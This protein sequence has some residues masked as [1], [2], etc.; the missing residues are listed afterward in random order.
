MMD[1]IHTNKAYE[2]ELKTLRDRILAM[3]GRVEKMIANS[4]KALVLNDIA[5]AKS[6]IEFDRGIDREEMLIDK[7][8]LEMLARRQ[9]LGQDLRFIVCVLKMVTYF[10][11][12]GDLAVKISQRVASLPPAT[13]DMKLDIIEAMGRSVQLMVRDTVEAFLLRDVHRAKSVLRQDD[14]LD[15]NYHQ[16]M[17][18]YILK[19]N[20]D[21]QDVEVY[22]HLLSIAKWLE[23]MG[24]HCTNVAELII[25][26]VHGEDIRHKILDQND[27]WTTL[28]P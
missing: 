13:S 24:D 21:H 27:N 16:C 25:F 12:L 22:F 6:T 19:L 26:M 7:M 17:R 5:L 9:P 18:L 15:E 10:E 14:A 2:H 23:R 1:K 28:V 8:C 20:K 4:I 3:A 11:R